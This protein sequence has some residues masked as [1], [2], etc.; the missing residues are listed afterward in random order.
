MDYKRILWSAFESTGTVRDY[1]KFKLFEEEKFDAVVNFAAESHV[2]RSIE[3]PE[4]FLK[5]NILGTQVLL[6][7][8]SLC[9]I[10]AFDMPDTIF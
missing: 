10:I 7:A 8:C 4:V 6:D 2:D 5:T 3:N 1:L 9:C